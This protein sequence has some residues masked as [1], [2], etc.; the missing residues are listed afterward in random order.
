[1]SDRSWMYG[2]IAAWWPAETPAVRMDGAVIQAVDSI[3]KCFAS[4]R[5]DLDLEFMVHSNV[6]WTPWRKSLDDAP[7]GQARSPARLQ[8]C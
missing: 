6:D 8:I 3:R 7:L 1:M 2:T 5:G 4:I